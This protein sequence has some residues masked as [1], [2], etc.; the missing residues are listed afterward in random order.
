MIEKNKYIIVNNS[1][2]ALEQAVLHKNNFKYI[3]GGTDVMVNKY[4][5]NEK[6]TCFI[7]L[8]KIT[9]LNVIKKENTILKIGSLV[10]LDNL[11]KNTIIQNEF[12][13][14]IEAAASVGTPLIRKSATLGGNILCENRCIFYNQSEWWRESVGYCLKCNGDICIATGGKNACFSEMIS[15]TAPALIAMNADIEYL[16]ENGINVIKL[17]DIYTGDGVKPRNLPST[18]LILNII[19][20]L[21][22]NYKYVFNKLRERESLEFTS[23]T[24]AVTLNSLNKILISL[25]GVD[26]K[27]IFIESDL[28]ENVDDVIKKATKAART[29]DNDMYTRKYRREMIG[30]Y[31]RNSY[32]KL[33]EF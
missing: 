10:T 12:P 20:P 5:G 24:C 29:V 30:I 23:L 11:K 8:T 18:A 21:N 17:K 3:A 27:P 2:H 4:Q 32:K 28:N 6:S 31:I 9:E 15:D 1:V 7:D 22:Q 14:L 13:L 19:L 33:M 26:P 16:D 25:S